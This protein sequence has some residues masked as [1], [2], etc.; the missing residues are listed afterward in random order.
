MIDELHAQLAQVDAFVADDVVP[1]ANGRTLLPGAVN[2]LKELAELRSR[3]RQLAVNADAERRGKLEQYDEYCGL[4]Q[5][6][7]VK[8]MQRKS[9][10]Q[11]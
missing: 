7:Y 3:I 10:N 1:I 2:V 6:V 9:A 5:D 11:P 4:L 8:A